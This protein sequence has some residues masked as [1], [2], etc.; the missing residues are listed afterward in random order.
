MGANLVVLADFTP[1]GDRSLDLLFARIGGR[2]RKAGWPVR[3]LFYAPPA[4][5]FAREIESQGVEWGTAPFPPRTDP[6]RWS[7]P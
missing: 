4:Q 1:R 5:E 6:T 7:S 2:I 3:M